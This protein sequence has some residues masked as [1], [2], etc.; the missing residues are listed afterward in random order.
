MYNEINRTKKGAIAALTIAMAVVLPLLFHS[1]PNAG[2]I[3][4]PMHIP[5]LLCGLVTGP[6]FGFI[7]GVLSPV[8]SSII[9]GMPPFA[10][11]PPMIIECAIYGLSTGL[12]MKIK[13]GKTGVDVFASVI[14]AMLLGR[15]V[16]GIAKALIFARGSFTME[17]FISSYFITGLP[18]IIIHIIVVPF[19]YTML[20][21]A[22]LIPVRY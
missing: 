11:L 9:T 7:A 19:L 6:F 15:I 1:I 14:I 5:V 10:Y 18:G 13:T 16:A 8:F 21:K 3:Y 12:M 4:S 17:L 2:S 20:E 22:R